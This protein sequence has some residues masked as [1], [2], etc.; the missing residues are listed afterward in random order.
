MIP[1]TPQQQGI[2]MNRVRTTALT[3]L[4][5]FGPFGFADDEPAW[6]AATPKQTV[7]VIVPAKAPTSLPIPTP[8]VVPAPETLD[9]NKAKTPAT[10]QPE[11][12]AP[13]PLPVIAPPPPAEVPAP[14]AFP[15]IVSDFTQSTASQP[16]PVEG[17]GAAQHRVRSSESEEK[18][19]HPVPKRDDPLPQGE[20]VKTVI[21]APP[22]FRAC[23]AAP[24][25]PP[26]KIPPAKDDPKTLPVPK[27]LPPIP[28]PA[29]LPPVGPMCPDAPLEPVPGMFT[30]PLPNTSRHGVYGSPGVRLSRDYSFCDG[31]GLDMQQPVRDFSVAGPPADS[32]LVQNEVLFW[33][34]NPARIPVL[35][36]TNT[37][38]NVG[39]L[40][41]P[42]TQ[43]LLGPGT[44]GPTFQV[45]YRVR[46]GG[47]FENDCESSRGF[48]ASFFFLG[49][50]SQ[51]YTADG[52]PVI[53][54]PF[55]AAGD[56]N[57][58]ET[59]ALPGRAI[60]R[61]TADA[62]RFLWGADINYKCAVCR[63][64]DRTS[65][66]FAGY[67]VLNLR[68]TL[69]MQEFITATSAVPDPIGTQ[70]YVQDQ[71]RTTNT[72]NGGQVGY[73]LNRR[74]GRFD[75][76]FRTSVAIG[77]TRE[78][79]QIDGYQ[80]RTRPGQA[81]ETFTG[82][83]LAVGPNLGSFSQ[84]RFAV[85]PETTVN[86]GYAITPNVRMYVGYN[87]L[88][89][90]RVIRPGDQIDPV[91][92][93]GLVPNLMAAIPASTEARPQPTFT[94]AD[95]IVQGMQLGLELRW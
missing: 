62:D 85:V 90:S 60:G 53:S 88:Y 9:W 6:K 94:Q 18:T 87:F 29:P 82:G 32:W 44:F 39:I 3:A 17:E 56:G 49:G 55:I 22:E 43:N 38:G 75:A 11:A 76:D 93:A 50:S 86:L 16:S 54:R 30:S 68:E 46:A 57:T 48:D 95:L 19:P 67:R 23:E 78:T 1:E 5:L 26:E 34:T 66:W 27:E 71:F 89:W 74:S 12:P 36:T 10:P 81:T 35:A 41:R 83:L 52:L 20:K 91:L 42:G 51:N 47:W 2:G 61:F 70:V 80:Q 37:L 25:A 69:T 92:N 59:V 4:G 7:I 65:A 33:F 64:C 15:V 63:T 21:D 77:A 84:T 79:V 58:A 72:F 45:G 40:G 73:A 31:F 8:P 24:V 28:P 14:P 13:A